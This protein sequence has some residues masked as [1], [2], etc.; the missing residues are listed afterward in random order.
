M[1]GSASF[2]LSQAAIHFKA[3]I[4]FQT[5]D[6]PSY[7]RL[8]SI[9]V[10]QGDIQEGLNYYRRALDLYQAHAKQLLSRL[11]ITLAVPLPTA[12]HKQVPP[13]FLVEYTLNWLDG[14]WGEGE[15]YER[16]RLHA[17]LALR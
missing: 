8:A 1:V 2:V 12:Q 16:S 15:A 10:A 13:F 7:H 5:T 3:A 11:S 4:S 17:G 14:S 9:L 6:L